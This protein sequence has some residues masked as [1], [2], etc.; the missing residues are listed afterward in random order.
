MNGLMYSL[1]R[2]VAGLVSSS[3]AAN[4]Y[5]ASYSPLQPALFNLDSAI[6]TYQ[7][8]WDLYDQNGLYESLAA[9]LNEQGVWRES[10]QSLR[11]P[12]NRVAEFYAAKL[13]PGADLSVALPIVTDNKAIKAPI[14][15]VWTW[16]NWASQKQVAARWLAIYGD[17]FIKVVG[18]VDPLGTVPPR[19][20]FELIQ[21]EKVTDIDTDER[22]FLTY[23]RIDTPVWR[24]E[25]DKQVARTVTEVWDKGNDRFRK[26]EH[27]KGER[28]ELKDLGKPE[29]DV[30]IVDT[31]GVNFIPIVQIRF[32]D[33][34]KPRGSG[35]YAHA[36]DKITEANRSATRLHQMLFRHNDATMVLRAG[37]VDA[38]MRPLPSPRIGNQAGNTASPDTITIG[39]TKLFRLPGNA[40]L[41][42][43]VP[44][45]H[46]GE[47]L[48]ILNAMMMEL[49]HDLPELAYYRLRD[50]GSN[51]SGRA[52]RLLL[53]D[54]I[55][56][57]NEARG[58]AESGLVRADQMA[59]TIGKKIKVPSFGF[60]GTF[61]D[62]SFDH[63]F[64]ARPV[65][66]SD[67]LEDA[68][69]AMLRQ[70]LG[71]PD[72]QLQR[73]LGYSDEAIQKMA[74]EK[75]AQQD[76]LGTQLIDQFNR[77]QG[78][79]NGAGVQPQP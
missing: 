68:Q 26:W 13:W 16:S 25:G 7:A 18:R 46:Y 11:T 74:A 27:E 60:P 34:G 79:L 77:G 71:V 20:Y 14:E 47:A 73:E 50:L 59:L 21:P 29:P 2:L 8:M 33:T 44:N 31:F 54:A 22:G 70:S 10:L 41:Q 3:T 57:V 17:L 39:D 4:T 12:A 48:D 36:F 67:E 52:V 76:A 30:S 58:N 49:E 9:L 42:Q 75:Q 45:L 24:R 65:L 78:N 72:S 32:R 61:E 15:Q 53:S 40:E 55:D 5:R 63:S 38:Q 69:A 23:V 66:P 56:R 35:S 19:V 51:I 43:L 62:G 64:A 6:L 1:N 28:A 37:G